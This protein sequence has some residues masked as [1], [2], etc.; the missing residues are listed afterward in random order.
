MYKQEFLD[1]MEEKLK[2][3]RTAIEAEINKLSAPEEAMDNPNAEDLAQDAAEDIIE[4][5]LLRVHRDILNRI[6]DALYR[7]KDG[8]YG[9]C[10]QCGT[11]ISQEDLDREPWVEHCEKCNKK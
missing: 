7:I 3:E 9:R 11:E 5:S 10:I 6:E 8:T 2:K 1:K 4:E